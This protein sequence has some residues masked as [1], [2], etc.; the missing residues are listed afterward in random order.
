[1][2]RTKRHEAREIRGRILKVLHTNYPLPAGDHL[3]SEI[4]TDAQ[5]NVSPAQVEV[6]L[7][8]LSEKG[9]IE[10]SA[11]SSQE[12]SLT[13]NLAKLTATGVDLLE[14]NIESDPGVMLQ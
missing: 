7:T 5:Y 11:V 1:M 9:Y 2:N 10:L 12:L 8:Y 3:L 13:R 14:G 4:L 6:H